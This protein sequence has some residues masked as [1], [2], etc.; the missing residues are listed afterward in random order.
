MST[1]FELLLTELLRSS[2]V[3]ERPK[4]SFSLHSTEIEFLA[5]K[6]LLLPDEYIQLFFCRFCFG[7]SPSDASAVFS[8]DMP[9][10]KLDFAVNLLSSLL[11]RED[12]V[13]DAPSLAAAA[14]LALEYYTAVD[15][16]ITATP[17]YSRSFRKKLKPLK[18][19]H[20]TAYSRPIIT[21]QRAAMVLLAC[22]VVITSVIAA[23]RDLRSNIKDFFTPTD[24]SFSS[25]DSIISD[26]SSQNSGLSSASPKPESSKSSEK[27]SSGISKTESFSSKES[28]E[29]SSAEDG[30]DH[31]NIGTG[32]DDPSSS[33]DEKSHPPANDPG[34]IRFTAAYIPDGFHYNGSIKTEV[35]ARYDYFNPKTVQAFYI[36]VDTHP[37]SGFES[38]NPTEIT[39]KNAPAFFY[40]SDGYRCL[41]WSQKGT[42]FIVYGDLSL[43]ELIKIAEGITN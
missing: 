19:I 41:A 39:L 29:T 7:Q 6:I 23:N 31:E 30:S 36:A 10:E 38:Y 12:A 4:P 26:F 24:S 13:P 34:P 5:Q 40:E 17:H 28:D 33:S 18:S 8:I 11:G 14:E 2:P 1:E 21:L 20:T 15:T 27:D 16:S 22:G 9:V 35:S 37:V 25:E 32:G 42:D 3:P 43:E